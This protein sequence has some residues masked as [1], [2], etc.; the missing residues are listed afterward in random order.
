[1]A[2][3]HIYLVAHAWYSQ[4][5][6]MADGGIKYCWHSNSKNIRNWIRFGGRNTKPLD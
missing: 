5:M 1:M 2:I 3:F 4:E 6:G